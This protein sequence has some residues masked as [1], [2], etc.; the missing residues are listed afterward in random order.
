MSCWPE[1]TPRYWLFVKREVSEP[2]LSKSQM[3]AC[4]GGE[5]TPVVPAHLFWFDGKFVEKN[6]AEVMRMRGRHTD[7]FIHSYPR[8]EK[9]ARDPEMKPGE[10]ADEWGCLFCGAPDGVGA[11]PTRAIVNTIAEWEHYAAEKFP[12]INPDVFATGIR[13]IVSSNPGRYVVAPFWRTFYERMYM[14]IGFENL[15]ME[16]ATD[17]E[18]FQRMRADLRDFTIRGIESIADAG[19]DA[20]FLAD[21]WGTQDRLQISPAMWREFF[22]PAYSAMI[23]ARLPSLAAWMSSSIS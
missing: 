8:L 15:M 11:H 19:A 20:V 5:H 4:L 2:M 21:D 7:D 17:G 10:F 3:K 9:R 6:Q 1:A 14:L 23:A 16:I 12:R 13:E 22:R 18:L